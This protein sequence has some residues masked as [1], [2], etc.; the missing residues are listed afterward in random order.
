MDM[1]NVVDPG[2]A[3]FPCMGPEVC[4]NSIDNQMRTGK[5]A[6]SKNHAYGIVMAFL[7]FAFVLLRA[8]VMYV[9]C[10]MGIS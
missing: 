3:L 4:T 5:H 6:T 2:E 7:Y 1:P 9:T 10:D 8:V